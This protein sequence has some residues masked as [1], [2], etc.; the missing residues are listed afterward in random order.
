MLRLYLTLIS[1]DKYIFL[2]GLFLSLLTAF[3]GIALLAVSGW[4]ISAAALAGITTATAHAFNF[5]TPGAIVRGLSITRTAGRYGERLANHEATFRLI[6]K[7]RSQIFKQLGDKQNVS[8]LMNR[9]DTGSQLLQ[10]INNIESIHLNALIPALSAWCTAIGFLA[11]CWLFLPQMA[12]ISL[13]LLVTSLVIIPWGY[14]SAVVQ[15]ESELHL[16]RSMVWSRTSALFSSM[17]LLTLTQ[18]INQQGKLLREDAK[19]ADQFEMAALK[20]QQLMLLIAQTSGLTLLGCTLFFAISAYQNGEMAGSQIFMMM[21]LVLGT[22]EVI[23]GANSALGHLLL[24]RRALARLEHL[25][26][27]SKTRQDSRQFSAALEQGVRLTDIHF[28]YSNANTPVF[29]GFTLSFTTRGIFWLMGESGRGKTTLLKLLAGELAPSQGHV[30]LN[31]HGPEQIGYMPQQVQVIRSSLRQNLDLNAEFS[32]Q[33]IWQA[34]EKV[35][36]AE[37]ARGL[38]KGLDTWIGKGEWEPS[39]GETKRIGLARMFLLQPQIILLDEPFS[40]MENA[41][42]LSL[43]NQL[44]K[45]WC[46]SLVIIVSHDLGLRSDDETSLTL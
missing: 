29:K 8:A 13:P 40:G 19:R 6:A 9:H 28:Q 3:A 41:L 43:L 39:G 26:T 22:N 4:F 2:L 21:L 10:D 17:R 15:P 1:A 18:Q 34:L 12:L 16:H 32:D 24:G 46:Q 36:L 35:E 44:R 30:L 27:A 45:D 5:F 31:A 38:P 33:K 37:W 11:M 20:R 23:A 42:Q 7:L 14:A 25:T